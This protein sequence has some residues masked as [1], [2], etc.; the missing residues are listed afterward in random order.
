[1]IISATALGWLV[2]TATLITALVPGVLMILWIRDW[3]RGQL[4]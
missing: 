2:G 3:L 4:W 1:M